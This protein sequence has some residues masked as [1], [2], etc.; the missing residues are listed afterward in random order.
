MDGATKAIL[1]LL[2]TW[3]VSFPLTCLAHELGH[4]VAVR[5]R[6]GRRAL[7]VV[8]REDPL[9]RLRL[10]FCDLE[11]HPIVEETWCWFDPKGVTVGE[12]RSIARAGSFG[13]ALLAAC[14]AGLA[15]WVADPG[16]VLFWIAVAGLVV[17]AFGAIVELIPARGHG[18]AVSDGGQMARLRGRRHDEPA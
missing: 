17:S 8:G 13:D 14:F 10:G 6:T 18:G 3:L 15:Y 4:A 7:V 12:L 16:S 1:V 9:L 5:R 11:F 2:V